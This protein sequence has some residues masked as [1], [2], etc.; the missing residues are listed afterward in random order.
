[1]L[2]ED[3]QTRGL[4]ESNWNRFTIL[5]PLHP[6][7]AKNGSHRTKFTSRCEAVGSTSSYSLKLMMF[8]SLTSFVI[9]ANSVWSW[10][11]STLIV[12][13]LERGKEIRGFSLHLS[14]VHCWLTAYRNRWQGGCATRTLCIV[15]LKKQQEKYNLRILVP[16][17]NDSLKQWD[18]IKL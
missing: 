17:K 6:L 18:R 4:V 7:S 15:Y 9:C 12:P 16:F 14:T 8:V 13:H 10:D 3:R 1:M 5:K 11:V 2:G